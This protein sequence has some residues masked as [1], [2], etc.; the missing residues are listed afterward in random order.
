MHKDGAFSKKWKN[1]ARL[2]GFKT[3]SN[4]FAP[5]SSY[6]K[7]WYKYITQRPIFIN[8]DYTFKLFAVTGRSIKVIHNYGHGGSGVTLFWGCAL[9]VLKMLK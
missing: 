3:W 2:G 6:N 4:L 8:D 7:N 5:R 1:P 9:D